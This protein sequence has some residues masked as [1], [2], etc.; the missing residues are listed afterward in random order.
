VVTL[1]IDSDAFIGVTYTC[2]VHACENKQNITVQ[3]GRRKEINRQS[4]K[5][6]QNKAVHRDILEIKTPS[7][8]AS[9]STNETRTPLHHYSSL[10]SNAQPQARLTEVSSTFDDASEFFS[11]VCRALY[12]SLRQYPGWNTVMDSTARMTIMPSSTKK[13]VSLPVVIPN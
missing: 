10:A 7:F 6:T 3:S 4:T 1:Y 5:E 2:S 12:A 11:A 13:Y 8:Y 9:K